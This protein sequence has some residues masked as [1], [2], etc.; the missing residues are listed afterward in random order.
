LLLSL[1]GGGWGTLAYLSKVRPFAVYLV[2][3][4]I[5][6]ALTA[7]RF[8]S[9]RAL[10]AA[11]IVFVNGGYLAE[12]T[13]ELVPRANLF[14]LVIGV[15]ADRFSPAPGPSSPTGIVCTRGFSPVYNNEYLIHALAEIPTT[16]DDIQA[17]FVS[18]GDLLDA[19]RSLADQV[20]A[21]AMRRRV[22]FLGGY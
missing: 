16:T 9:R 20:L 1:Y 21:P 11:D 5:L 19:T 3:S 8:M 6:M 14:P 18:A 7:K 22:K 2:G 4:D 12:K 13:R 10:S 15:D 17:T